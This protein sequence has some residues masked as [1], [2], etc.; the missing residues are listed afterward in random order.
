[1][2]VRFTAR[3]RADLLAQLDWLTTRSPDAARRAANEIGL[4]LGLLAH[5]PEAAP[6]VDDYYREAAMRF[7]RDGFVVRYRSM[8]TTSPSCG[9][10]TAGNRASAAEL[11]RQP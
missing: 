8:A 10:S 9:S 7:G 3:A 1:V 11:Y 6:A 5:F 4:H 2:K